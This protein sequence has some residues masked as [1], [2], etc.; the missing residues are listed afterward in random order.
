MEGLQPMNTTFTEYDHLILQSY[1]AVVE[2]LAEYLGP[3]SEIVLHSLEDYQHS[4]TKIA[5][6]HHTGREIG[7]P[8]TNRALEMLQEIEQSHVKKSLSYFTRSKNNRLMKSSTIAI[9]GDGGKIIG[10]LCINMNIDESFAEVLQTFLPQP[11]MES[12]GQAEHFT[13]SVEEMIQ[14]TIERTIEEV[15][16]S[17]DISYANRNKHIIGLLH[18]RGV[19]NMRDAVTIVANALRISK[20]TVYLH[21]RNLASKSEKAAK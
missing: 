5:N 14:A 6:G 11:D 10:L 21:L 1:D 7:A 19:F 17:Q 18:E 8:I 12:R 13:S 4:V 15:D 3:A 2:G 9:K 20:H 16:A